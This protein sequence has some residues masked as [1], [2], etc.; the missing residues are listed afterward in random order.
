MQRKEHA[1]PATS[2]PFH[3]RTA[4]SLIYRAVDRWLRLSE[5]SQVRELHITLSQTS[6]ACQMSHTLTLHTC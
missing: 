5:S 1:G 3:H 4:R 6:E 2:G